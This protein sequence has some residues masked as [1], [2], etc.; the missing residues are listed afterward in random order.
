M[1]TLPQREWDSSWLYG[2][3]LASR[4]NKDGPLKKNKT[5]REGTGARERERKMLEETRGRGQRLRDA[6]EGRCAERWPL[7]GVHRVWSRA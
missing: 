5:L 4:Q 1:A 6:G 3:L 7:L 2:H